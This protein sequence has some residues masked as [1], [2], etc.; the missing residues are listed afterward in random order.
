M[1]V[2]VAPIPHAQGKDLAIINQ[3]PS[4]TILDH[5]DENRRLAS[6]LLYKT[7][8][9]KENCLDWAIN[10]GYMG[11][12]KSVTESEDYQEAATTRGKDLNTLDRLLARNRTYST[13]EKVLNSLYVSPAFLGSSTARTQ[14]SGV[15][16]NALTST[17]TGAEYQAE[18][19]KLFDDAYNAC[20]LA[21][22]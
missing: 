6:W 3:G 18:L 11:I 12:R 2:G 8:T 1:D 14:V 16:T 7:I 20:L 5:D 13:N 15:L 21:V 19:N 22:K 4:L 17:K 9:N 10:S